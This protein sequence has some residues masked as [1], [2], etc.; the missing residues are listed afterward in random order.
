MLTNSINGTWLLLVGFFFFKYGFI[1]YKMHIMY[2]YLTNL[3]V[4]S[5]AISWVN[6]LKMKTEFLSLSLS[7]WVAETKAI[8]NRLDL[9][10]HFV[11]SRVLAMSWYCFRKVAH[12]PVTKHE[13]CQAAAAEKWCVC[14]WVSAGKKMSP[15][16]CLKVRTDCRAKCNQLCYESKLVNAK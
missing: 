11:L 13:Q 14:V 6:F 9:S 16:C 3:L 2:G 10:Q 5:V 15:K 1:K 8:H 12:F 4:D 7:V